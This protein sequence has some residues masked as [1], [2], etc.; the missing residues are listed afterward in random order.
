MISCRVTSAASAIWLYGY[1]PS[2][3]DRQTVRKIDLEALELG[4]PLDAKRLRVAHALD[5]HQ[6]QWQLWRRKKKQVQF[7]TP[8]SGLKISRAVVAAHIPCRYHRVP[9]T[10]CSRD[11]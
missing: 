7:A 8:L 10:F 6:Q 1:R 5:I 4:A 9:D 3:Y 2:R 11:K